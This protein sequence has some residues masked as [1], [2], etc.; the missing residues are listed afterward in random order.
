MMARRGHTKD[1][2]VHCSG[3]GSVTESGMTACEQC[4]EALDGDFQAMI[5]P[6]CATVVESDS[7]NCSS[8]GL[9][10]V[11]EKESRTKE[12]DEFLSKLLEWGKKLEAKRI[13]EDKRETDKATSILKDV[14][15]VVA[16]TPLQEETI[17]GIKKSAE[18]REEFERREDSIQ[19]MAEP[20]R[21]ALDLRKHSLDELENKYKSIQEDLHNLSEED[22]D[23]EKKRSNLERQLAEI[24]VERHSIQRLEDNIG[25]MDQA[26]RQLLKRH[27]AEI[28]EKEE[29]LNSRLKAFKTEMERR[30]KEK[31][32]LKA[33]EEF[34]EK[35]EREL[36]ARIESLKDREGSLKSTEERMR[37]EIAALEAERKGLADLKLPVAGIKQ[38]KGKWVL[39]SEELAGV[40][41]KSKKLR[42]DWL[43]E[44]SRIQESV[45]AGESGAQV[46]AE[47]EARI[48]GKEEELRLRIQELEK[49][50]V[51]ASAE[52]RSIAAEEKEVISDIKKLKKVLKVLDDLLENLPDEI[53][54]K[55]AKSKDFR[56]YEELM[57]ELGL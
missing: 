20:L 21:K 51:Q 52:E 38:A 42:E 39:D 33:R 25:N 12:D 44:Q 26:Y 49:R 41:R 8:C 48:E 13:E 11:T 16:A 54:A 56:E 5:C 4:G 15:G 3:C 45:A 17:I 34:L 37:E 18:E 29:N 14:M 1:G 9:K 43:E 23:S 27:S 46:A 22:L 28:K 32:R 10:F 47:S 55:F 57:D 2:K 40:L 30:E 50:L 7:G 6:Y 36:T 35:K 19:K 24:T 53:V 31:E